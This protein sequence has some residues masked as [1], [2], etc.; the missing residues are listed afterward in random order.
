METENQIFDKQKQRSIAYKSTFSTDLGKHVL[1]DI[2]LNCNMLHSSFSTDPLEMAR[3]EGERNVCLRILSIVETD[4]KELQNLIR[5]TNEYV[6][7]RNNT[8]S[9]Y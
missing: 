4:I 2:M 9:D 8:E 7:H 3:K 5:E 6:R 1:Y